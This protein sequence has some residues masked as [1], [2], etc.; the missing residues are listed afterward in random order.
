[1][2][3]Y[4]HF[5]SPTQFDVTFVFVPRPLCMHTHA[6]VVEMHFALLHVC[7]MV[8]FGTKAY[9]VPTASHEG[10]DIIL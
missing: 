8:Y 10:Y 1:M 3:V 6:G 7:E 4:E 9:E 5:P 2:Y